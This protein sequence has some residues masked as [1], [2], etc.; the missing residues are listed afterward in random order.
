MRVTPL[1][2]GNGARN[3]GFSLR[4]IDAEKAASRWSR[5][6]VANCGCA[7]PA[8]AEMKTGFDCSSGASSFQSIKTNKIDWKDAVHG[9]EINLFC[10]NSSSFHS[11]YAVF[12]F[13]FTWHS[14]QNRYN[15]FP[16]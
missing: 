1:Q 14:V 11:C 6:P 13:R 9:R 5:K 8:N 4:R 7:H 2:D 15:R 12:R 3:G 16:D 10:L